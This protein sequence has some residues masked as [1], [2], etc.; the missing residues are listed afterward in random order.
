MSYGNH[1][2]DM[3]YVA[4]SFEKA[5][6]SALEISGGVQP[7]FAH[8]I[9]P[10]MGES[11]GLNV[12]QAAEIKKAVHI[13]V[14]CVGKIHTAALAESLISAGKIDMATRDY[15]KYKDLHY[16]NGIEIASNT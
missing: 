15:R 5:G 1:L 16:F 3:I 2:E 9:I 7:E 13:P 10:C 14:L 11:R 8:H 4:K 6:V 12:V